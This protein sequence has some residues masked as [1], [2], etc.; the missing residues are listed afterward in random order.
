MA[1]AGGSGG[2]GAYDHTNFVEVCRHGSVE[3]V[4]ALLALTGEDRVDVHAMD[5]FAWRFACT[6]GHMDLV[7]LLL[8][9]TGDRRIDVHAGGEEAWRWACKNGHMDVVEL[10]LDLT[11]DR[12]INVHT[13]NEYAWRWAC[14]NG[15]TEV[16]KLLLGLTGDRLIDVHAGGEVAWRSV[17][18]KG[19]MDVVKALL[20]SGADRLPSR[21]AFEEGTRNYSKELR[22]YEHWVCRNN[23]RLQRLMQF[24]DT[25]LTRRGLAWMKRCCEEGRPLQL[26][27]VLRDL[28]AVKLLD[29]S[30][31]RGW[32]DVAQAKGHLDCVEVL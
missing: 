9:L 6:H 11:G 19:R 2:D 25:V 12:R 22:P 7:E 27:A 18:R 17:C 21:A 32:M 28:G 14:T 24:R 20:T 10:L 30:A 15:H 8:D 16:V 4:C 26:E 3:D 5:E 29:R 13:T 31:L 1:A 23:P